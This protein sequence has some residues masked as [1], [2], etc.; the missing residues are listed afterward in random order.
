MRKVD[1]GFP[2]LKRIQENITTH[3]TEATTRRW[4]WRVEKFAVYLE[5]CRMGNDHPTWMIRE[6]K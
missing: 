1:W 4:A 5:A 2:K 3:G 6:M